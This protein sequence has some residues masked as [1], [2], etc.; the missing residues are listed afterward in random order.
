[1]TGTDISKLIENKMIII[2][3]IVAA[4]ILALLIGGSWGVGLSNDVVAA[5]LFIVVLGIVAALVAGK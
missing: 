1:M 4:I 3:I 5:I 2:I